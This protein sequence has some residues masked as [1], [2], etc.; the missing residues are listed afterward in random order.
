MPSVGNASRRSLQRE[1]WLRCADGQ[2]AVDF[3]VLDDVGPVFDD[4]VSA[5]LLIVEEFSEVVG[6]VVE[7]QLSTCNSAMR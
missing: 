7:R 2:C 4:P 5:S 6:G 1:L 3:V